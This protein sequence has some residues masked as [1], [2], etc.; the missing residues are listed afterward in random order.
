VSQCLTIPRLIWQVDIDGCQS[1]FSRGE[2]R[3]LK[4]TFHNIGLHHM[5]GEEQSAF[6]LICELA[7]L[8]EIEVLQFSSGD[9]PHIQFNYDYEDDV[10]IHIDLANGGWRKTGVDKDNIHRLSGI[11]DIHADNYQDFLALEAHLQCKHD[12][13]ITA[14]NSILAIRDDFPQYNI[15]TPIEAAKIMGLFLRHRE[16]W[17]Y[18]SQ[19]GWQWI[20]DKR[21]F[22][23]IIMRSKLPSMWEY[24]S[25]CLNAGGYN[26]SLSTLASSIL[27]RCYTL[28]QAKDEIGNFSF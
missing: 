12:I 19:N 1:A 8:K 23:W 11:D 13:F 6:E 14:S 3:S 21:E 5:V 10:G 2:S 20:T 27:E 15:R 18:Y 24:F 17:A 7:N 25:E 28:L 26:G 9:F 4:L 16:N 22:Y